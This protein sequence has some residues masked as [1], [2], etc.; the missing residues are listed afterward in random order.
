LTGPR[1]IYLFTA[2]VTSLLALLTLTNLAASRRQ[3]QLR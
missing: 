2:A 1:G 3:S